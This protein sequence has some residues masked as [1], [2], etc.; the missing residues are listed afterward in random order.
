MQQVLF[1]LKLPFGILAA[2]RDALQLGK[3]S[4]AD[5][6]VAAPQMM[7]EKSQLVVT[8]ETIEPQGKL[9]QVDGQGIQ[10]HTVETVT[11]Y[12]PPPVIR[13]AG[14]RRG[15]VPNIGDLRKKADNQIGNLV[16]GVDKEMAATHTGVAEFED[17]DDFLDVALHQG[18]GRLGRTTP[19]GHVM[20]FLGFPD[21]EIES[22]PVVLGETIL[23][24]LNDRF[25]VE[26]PDQALRRVVRT[27]LLALQSGLTKINIAFFYETVV[28]LA[29]RLRSQQAFY[30]FLCP[31]AKAI[32]IG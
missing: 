14:R 3:V 19:D 24:G 7:V 5:K 1:F 6:A 31:A 26:K 9:G 27:G 25:A 23:Q 30:A 21:K 17:K 28:L 16:G 29:G 4:D 12:E 22:L 20:S 2:L 32:R 8:S 15:Q 18:D 10:I 11:G 13:L